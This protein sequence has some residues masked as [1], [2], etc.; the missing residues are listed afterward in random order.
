MEETTKKVFV[1]RKNLRV[2]QSRHKWYVDN[3]R[4][5][6][7]LEVGDHVFLKVSQMKGL[8]RFGNKEKLSPCFVVSFEILERVRVMVYMIT[9]P[10]KYV[11]MHDV[12]HVSI[13]RKYQPDLT[14][15]IQHEILLLKRDLTY[16]QK[17]ICI[18]NQQ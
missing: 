11:R 5:N 6:L 10:L 4:R 13:S 8:L 2:T 16:E 17:T 9:L 12:F 7:A 18:I 15:I 1:I 3:R 14:H